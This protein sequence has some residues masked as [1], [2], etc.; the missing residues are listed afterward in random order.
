[1]HSAQ[2]TLPRLH[3][4]PAVITPVIALS[5]PSDQV[6]YLSRP[7]SDQFRTDTS[8][9]V[10]HFGGITRS[11]RMSVLWPGNAYSECVEWLLFVASAN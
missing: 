6:S 9:D 3:T 1:M 8:G 11:L 2:I 5:L 10:Y 7:G 4:R